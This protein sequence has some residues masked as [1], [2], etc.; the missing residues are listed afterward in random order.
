MDIVDSV[1]GFVG[2]NLSLLLPVDQIWQ[3]TDYL[4]DLESDNWSE[5]LAQFRETALRLPDELLV[6][7]V[8]NM[9]T[10]EALPNYT[11]SL[12]HIAK[13]PTGITD[14]PWAHW[15]RGWTAEEN[16]HGDLLN[17]YLRLTGRVN[18]R[19]VETTVHHLIK[20]G[21][22]PGSEGNNQ[23]GLVYAAFQERATRMSHGNLAR[24]ADE[25]GE[26]N[27][28]LICRKIASD[29]T[30]HE[31]FYT[32]VVA[33][34]MDRDPEGTIL[35][36]RSM[37]KRMIAMPGARMNDGRTPDLFDHYA[38]VTQR[39][40]VYTSRDYGDI[41]RHLNNAWNV[42]RRSVSGKAARAQDYICQQPERFER[43]ADEI[44]EQVASQA[45]FSF[46]WIRDRKA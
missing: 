22:S 30:R 39:T 9:V 31:V 16:R 5:Q 29:E 42:G 35:A 28:A 23:A 24:L 46:S 8:G 19:S 44:G 27:L 40:G 10:E 2:E 43:F 20:N 17:T 1:Q 4:P 3:P 45:P 26:V 11:I 18:M 21:F 41:I 15:L 37:L 25:Q 7:L 38:A 32:K 36:Y 13:D 14:T 12:E 33:Q 34:L 6:V